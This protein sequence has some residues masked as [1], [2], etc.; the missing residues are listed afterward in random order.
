MR[1]KQRVSIALIY[2]TCLFSALWQSVSAEV[3]DWA[4]PIGKQRLIEAELTQDFFNLAPHFEGQQNKVFCGAAS[5]TIVANALR[6]QADGQQIPLDNSLVKTHETA[7]FPDG[8]SPLFHR[9]TQTSILANTPLTKAQLLG[10]PK[11]NKLSRDFGLQLSELAHIAR[12]LNLQVAQTFVEPAK[13]AQQQY[14]TALKQQLLNALNEQHQHIII[15]YSRA[16]LSQKGAGHFSPLAAYHKDSDS[17]L[18]MDVS[19][20]YQN[21]VWVSSN[22]LFEAMATTDVNRSRGFI[23]IQEAV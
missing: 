9:Y 13:L 6:V 19:N 21:W 23:V 3:V 20:T 1:I 14:H 17:F 4:T 7:Y 2:L 18:V 5:M 16:S 10:E 11:A 15:N 22:I 8:V 12:S